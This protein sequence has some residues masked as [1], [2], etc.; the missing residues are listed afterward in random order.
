MRARIHERVHAD[1]LAW[2]SNLVAISNPPNGTWFQPSLARYSRIQLGTFSRKC[3][4]FSKKATTE[5]VYNDAA[6][7]R[8]RL[9]SY[10]REMDVSDDVLALRALRATW[11]ELQEVWS[12]AA[13]PEDW[14]G[15]TM[16]D[17]RVVK[18]MLLGFCL[19]GAVPAEIGRLTSLG[20][21]YLVDNMLTSLPAEI[22]Q[23]TSLREL[24]LGDNQLTSLPAEIGQLTSL[25][26]LDLYGNRLT[27][28]PVEIW[29]LTSLRDL[30]FSGNQLTSVSAKIGQLTLLTELR[31]YNNQLTSLPAEIGQLTSLVKLMLFSNRLTSL[32]AEIGQLT[33]LKVLNLHGNQPSSLPAA[34]RELRAAGCNVYMDEGVTIDE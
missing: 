8:L 17:G 24:N 15:V 18:L 10:R 2:F 22:G 28:L 19:T 29:Q 7:S 30:S 20:G 31:L 1:A 12:E 26:E 4:I 34:I 5:K 3:H 14:Y 25:R 16:E 32:P 33:S 11:P 6:H 9:Y 23:L 13:Q 21:L 27:S